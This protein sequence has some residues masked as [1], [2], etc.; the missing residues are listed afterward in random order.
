MNSRRNAKGRSG[1]RQPAH[2]VLNGRPVAC[3]HEGAVGAPDAGRGSGPEAEWKVCLHEGGH[4]A[5]ARALGCT[6]GRIYLLDTNVAQCHYSRSP[7]K[8]DEPLGILVVMAGWAAEELAASHAP[9]PVEPVPAPALTDP[10][11]SAA[12][13]ATIGDSMTDSEKLTRWVVG[14]VTINGWFWSTPDGVVQGLKGCAD[15][16]IEAR[17]AARALV[18][19]HRAAILRVAEALYARRLLAAGEVDDLLSGET[20]EPPAGP[21]APAATEAAETADGDTAGPTDLTA[22]AEA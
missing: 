22:A 16:F 17:D 15:G 7:E 19:E 2:P 6:P 11:V 3:L 12:M 10:S 20:Q 8:S 18:K 21:S 14:K 1:R 4:A 5:I 9:P 13:R